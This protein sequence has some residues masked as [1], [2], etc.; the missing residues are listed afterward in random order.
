MVEGHASNVKV[1][2][3]IPQAA[4]APSSADLERLTTNQEV[5]GSNPLGRLYTPSSKD[6]RPLPKRKDAGS[7]PVG[8]TGLRK[9]RHGVNLSSRL[10]DSLSSQVSVKTWPG[11]TSQGS[12][13]NPDTCALSSM[14]EPPCSKRWVVGSSPTG[15][16]GAKGTGSLPDLIALRP[17]VISATRCLTTWH[18]SENRNRSR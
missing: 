17:K 11:F 8:C 13:S 4:H 15:R 2:V 3:R 1:R 10:T 12:P 9:L 7:T 16:T 14:A 18:K 5:M 6:E